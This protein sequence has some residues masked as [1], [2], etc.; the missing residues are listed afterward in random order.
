LQGFKPIH[1]PSNTG[2]GVVL[3]GLSVVFGFAMFWS[4]WWLAAVS[5]AGLL[6]VA[7]DFCA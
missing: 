2:A 7:T 6:A 4:M 5:F 1:M 3:A